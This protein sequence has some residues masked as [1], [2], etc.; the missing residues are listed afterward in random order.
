MSSR[1]SRIKVRN[2]GKIAIKSIKFISLENNVKS[3]LDC[4]K[5]YP[6]KNFSFLGQHINL[7]I[8]SMVKKVTAT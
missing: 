3:H 5:V 2:T 8:Y 6:K 1:P 7:T 4:I